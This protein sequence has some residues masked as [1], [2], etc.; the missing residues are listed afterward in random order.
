MQVVDE[1]IV[2]EV[3]GG[4]LFPVDAST[5]DHGLQGLLL[6][7]LALERFAYLFEAVSSERHTNMVNVHDNSYLLN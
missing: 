6:T 1:F 3:F 5:R 2:F 4:S 7:A